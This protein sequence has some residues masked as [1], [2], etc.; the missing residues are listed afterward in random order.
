MVKSLV[1][2]PPVSVEILLSDLLPPFFVIKQALERRR[3]D[4]SPQHIRLRLPPE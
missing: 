3:A 2:D 1:F 4:I